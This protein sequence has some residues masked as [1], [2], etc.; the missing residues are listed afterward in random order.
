MAPRL[1]STAPG[2]PFP[3]LR[4][5]VALNA[6]VAVAGEARCQE[7]LEAEKT[8]KRRLGFLLRVHSRINTLRRA[9]ARQALTELARG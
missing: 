6:A 3:E 4:T 7:L 1:V 8:G 9:R 5:W 2:D